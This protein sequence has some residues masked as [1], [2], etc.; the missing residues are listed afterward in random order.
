MVEEHRKLAVIMFTDIVGYTALAQQDESLALELLKEH[1]RLLRESFSV[2]SGREIKCTGDGFLVVFESPVRSVECALSIQSRC[3]QRNAGVGADRGFLVRIGIHLGDI[4]YRDQDVFGDGVNVASRIEPLASPGGIAISRQVY[5]QVWNK[6][7][8]KFAR[9]GQK[10]LKNL[11]APIEV[12]SVTS[13]AIGGKV[14]EQ[15]RTR[16]AVLPL[17]NISSD[18]SDEY[19]ADGMTEELI[20]TLSKVRDLHVIANTSSMRYKNSDKSVTDIGQEL[21]IGSVLEG[22]VRK[23]GDMLRITVQLINVGN[24]EHIWSERYD[25]EL[26]DVFAIQSDIAKSVA[27]ALEVQLLATERHGIE[28]KATE[29]SEAYTLFLRGRYFLRKRTSGDL[30]KAGKY[31]KQAIELDSGYALAYAGL[32][33]HYFTLPEYGVV[34]PKTVLPKA[35]AAAEKA[36]QI[37]STVAEA[38]TTLAMLSFLQDRDPAAAERGFKRTIGLHPNSAEAHRQYGFMLMCLGRCGEAV[39]ETEKALELDPLS[40]LANRQVGIVLY[41]ARSYDKAIEAVRKAFELYPHY[42]SGHVIIGCAYLGK[43]MHREA[44]AEFEADSVDPQSVVMPLVGV[45]YVDM[46]RRDRAQQILA[47]S[48]EEAEHGHVTVGTLAA[49][50]FA[51]GQN[52]QGFRYLEEAYE[53]A[54]MWLRFLQVSHLF[55]SVRS[56]PRLASLLKRM[57]LDG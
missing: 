28:K 19:F 1:H 48:A 29:N 46:G 3:E 16:I 5:D 24:Q 47:E 38:L 40:L 15:D 35:K 6:I 41:S 14:L 11:R 17:T 42:A 9:L 39:E 7:P 27:E 50:C 34:N 33:E 23:A 53:E 30:E 32:A 45:T 4:V 2:H 57:G 36:L 49:L 37:D 43:G 54:D 26:D 21:R 25:R 18:S 13:S 20:Y 56:D 31:F 51:L 44:L 52:D 8:A 55:D 12:F 22:S 10:K